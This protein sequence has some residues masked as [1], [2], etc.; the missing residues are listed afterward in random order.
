[1]PNLKKSK[2]QAMKDP[3]KILIETIVFAIVFLAIYTSTMY[4][5]EKRHYE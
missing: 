3:V 5:I 4:F 1:M 2:D